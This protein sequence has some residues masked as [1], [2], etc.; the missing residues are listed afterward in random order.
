[1]KTTLLNQRPI[2]AFPIIEFK[3]AILDY[4]TLYRCLHR[5]GNHKLFLHEL[6]KSNL[7]LSRSFKDQSSTGKIIF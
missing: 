2:P 7:H 3:Y 5:E 1:M 4:L 6:V